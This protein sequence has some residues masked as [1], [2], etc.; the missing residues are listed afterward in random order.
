M[1]TFRGF[2]NNPVH[3]TLDSDK[4]FV[5]PNDGW[6]VVQAATDSPAPSLNPVIRVGG[7]TGG[8]APTYAEATGIMSG[9]SAFFASFPVKKGVKYYIGTY[10]STISYVRF[11][12]GG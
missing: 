1:S 12:G 8:N 7:T 11:F 2:T 10:R 6:V 4:A 3:I 9:N 5:A